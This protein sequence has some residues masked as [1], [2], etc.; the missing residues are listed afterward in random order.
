[1]YALQWALAVDF[2]P[3]SPLKGQEEISAECARDFSCVVGLGTL[4]MLFWFCLNVLSLISFV[5]LYKAL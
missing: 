1:M 4:M 2:G 3:V 5:F